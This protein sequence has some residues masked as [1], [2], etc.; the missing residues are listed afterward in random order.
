MRGTRGI[1]IAALL[2]A[3]AACTGGSM[4]QTGPVRHPAA[5]PTANNPYG[6]LGDVRVWASCDRRTK[7]AAVEN[8]SFFPI[9]VTRVAVTTPED[10][11]EMEDV[12]KR[13]LQHPIAR[14]VK[15]GPN[16][17]IASFQA[18]MDVRDADGFI[19][20]IAGLV[21]GGYTV[22]PGIH[23]TDMRRK[24]GSFV[25]IHVDCANDVNQG[26]V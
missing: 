25:R 22:G 4:S 26:P 12:V 24:P 1:L 23:M 9:T 20:E 18:P 13:L 11:V 6:N 2:A 15:V 16:G 17:D 21:P 5:T 8:L 7:G 10:R 19:I 14:S 3:L